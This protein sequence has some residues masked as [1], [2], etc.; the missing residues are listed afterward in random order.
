MML[1]LV[2]IATVVLVFPEVSNLW[3]SIFV[4]FSGFTASVTALGD[5]LVSAEES[6]HEQAQARSGS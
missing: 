3:V 2:A 5:L 1:N 6:D 4:L